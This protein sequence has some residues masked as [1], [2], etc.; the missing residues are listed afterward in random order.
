MPHPVAPTTSFDLTWTPAGGLNS[1][2]QQVQ[3]KDVVSP[4]WVTVATVSR[5][6]SSYTI[7]SLNYN[8][9]FEFR[10][11]SICTYGGPSP[12]NSF[13]SIN[14]S[15]PTVTVNPSYD[16]VSFSFEQLGASIT[17]YQVDLLS[18]VDS[19]MIASQTIHTTNPVTGSFS[20][21][22]FST[23]YQL[24]ITPRAAEFTRE[25]PPIPFT[26]TALPICYPPTDLTISTP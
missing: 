11:I 18:G 25:C 1:T 12:S 22:T 19:S 7:S 5:T 8:V 6:T 14:I 20:G 10:I 13:R 3:Y 16:S 17:D 26:T 15:C 2:G 23:S 9:I 24:V 4:D 21:L